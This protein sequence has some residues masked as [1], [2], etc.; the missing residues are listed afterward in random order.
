M[1][2][3]EEERERY[4]RQL[5]IPEFGETGQ[6][7]LKQ[8]KVL[9]IGAGGLGSPA[10]MYL[11]A[12]GVG[13][14]GIADSDVVDNS[15]L[16]RQILHGTSDRNRLKVESAAE[17]L[18][19][20]NSHV[21]VIPIHTMVTAENIQELIAD[22]DFVLDATDNYKAKFLINDGCVAAGKAYSHGGILAFSGQLMTYVPG[23][24]PCY[25]C[26][27]GEEPKPGEAPTA[28]EAGVIG[29]VA[30]IIGSMQAAEAIKYLIGKGR[31]LTGRMV[32][33]DAFTMRIREI[34]LPEANPDCK[35]CGCHKE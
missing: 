25:R 7:K 34:P 29:P 26:I 8:S 22:Y 4:S 30:G 10:S 9:V 20:I 23:Q 24:G 33:V 19:D 17:T 1:S 11:A 27:F 12:A 6:E 31:L 21:E 13:T 18:R 32:T 15:N 5:L 28:K 3:T 35:A 2:L 16:Q 14:I